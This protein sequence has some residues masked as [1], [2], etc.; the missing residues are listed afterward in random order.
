MKF[1]DIIK[2]YFRRHNTLH[3]ISD[4]GEYYDYSEYNKAGDISVVPC[5]RQR[6]WAYCQLLMIA[7]YYNSKQEKNPE[8]GYEICYESSKNKYTIVSLGDTKYSGIRFQ[9]R[10]DAQAVIDNF[11]FRKILDRVYENYKDEKV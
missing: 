11:N 6:I 10:L 1:E 3:A 4:D 8:E 2:D 9:K 7:D 5:A